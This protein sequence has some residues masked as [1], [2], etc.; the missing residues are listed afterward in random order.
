VRI[1]SRIRALFLPLLVAPL[2][3]VGF[4][5]WFAA[6]DGITAIARDFL[7][8]KLQEL[9][10]FTSTQYSLLDSNDLTGEATFRAAAIDA[11]AG[12]ADRLSESETELVLAVDGGGSLAFASGEITAAD[13]ARLAASPPEPGWSRFTVGGTDRVGAV[14]RFE[15]FDW[16]L[17]VSEAE[18]TFFAPVDRITRQS[19]IAGLV[20][21][22]AVLIVVGIMSRLITSPLRDTVSAMR[23]VIADGDLT[24]RVRARFDDETGELADSFNYMIGSLDEAYADIKKFALS[25]AYSEKREAKIRT[26]F[27]RYVPQHVISQ[28][29]EAPE[30]MLVGDERPLTVLY[31][32]VRGFTSFSES[33]ASHDVVESLNR[34]FGLMVE[35]VEGNSGIVDKY[36]GDAVMAF[37]GAPV[38]NENSPRDAVMAAFHMLSALD[39]FNEWQVSRGR[40]R[41]EIGIAINHGPVTVGNIG[42]DR[43]MDYTVIGDMVNVASRV[44]GLTKVYRQQI[45]VTESVRRY[46]RGVFPVRMVDRVQVV[47]RERGLAVWSVKPFLEPGEEEGWKAYHAGLVQYYNRE[48]RAAIGL[49]EKASRFM[50]GDHLCTMFA[51]RAQGCLEDP[52]DESWNGLVRLESK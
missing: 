18:T 36:I 16:L 14:A 29:F 42:S 46:I 11:I 17:V 26:V 52:P 8:F 37:F 19:A 49:F 31:S 24:R 4:S 27:Q 50:P 38:A 45:L 48:F 43:K 20:S 25:A 15:P 39:D 23:S 30:S 44:E 47:G 7:T 51:E 13:A 21:L 1:A 40:R 5:S 9:V 41:F 12:Y 32:D 28:F 33:L 10:R 35:A 6:Q 3:F 22:I 2:A 34:Y